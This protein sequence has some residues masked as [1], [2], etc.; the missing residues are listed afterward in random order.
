MGNKF[1]KWLG[2]G[3]GGGGGGVKIVKPNE[4]KKE[5]KIVMVGD[6]TVGKTALVVNYKSGTFNAEYTPNLLDV[7]R[8]ERDYNGEN[9]SLHI[10]DT[11]GDPLLGELRQVTY[12]RTDCFMLCFAVD[13]RNSFDNVQTKWKI[14]LANSMPRTPI[15]LVATKIDKMNAPGAI[16]E[17]EMEEIMNTVSA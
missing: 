11:S 10:H 2:G 15:L 1:R 16:T 8:G 9:I 13:N 12:N 14:E 4:T 6:A 3:G 7:Y 5:I 17:R